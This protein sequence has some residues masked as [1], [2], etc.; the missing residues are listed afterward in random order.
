MLNNAA[1]ASPPLAEAR[2]IR[3]TGAQHPNEERV[4][5]AAGLTPE[6]HGQCLASPADAVC[7]R[8]SRKRL[9]SASV[10]DA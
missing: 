4:H 3:R 5:P 10:S 8:L 2:G 9:L 6:E 1:V 7:G